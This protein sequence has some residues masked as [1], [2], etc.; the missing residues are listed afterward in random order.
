MSLVYIV[1]QGG[2]NTE[3]KYPFQGTQK[4]CRFKSSNTGATLRSYQRVKKGNEKDLISAV[5]LE[6]PIAAGI[7]ASHNT[8]R[9]GPCLT[10]T[11]HYNGALEKYIYKVFNTELL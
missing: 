6:G 5:A 2:I 3:S 1:D 11:N 8:F 10:F 9:V 7:D 4:K